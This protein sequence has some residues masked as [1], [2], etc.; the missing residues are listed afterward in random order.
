MSVYMEDELLAAGRSLEDLRKRWEGYWIFSLT[1]GQL[2]NEF[3]Q[4]VLRDPQ[5]DFPGH[6][7]VRDPT[8][9][10]SQSKRSRMAASCELVCGPYEETAPGEEAA[11]NQTADSLSG[12]THDVAGLGFLL[13]V[14]RKL[15][16]M[17]RA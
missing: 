2:K 17:I 14:W 13:K 3:G 11:R 12:G 1:V 16:S 4:E 15:R 7:L 9:K 6:G 10:R 8:G 5:P